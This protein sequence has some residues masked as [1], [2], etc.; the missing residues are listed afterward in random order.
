MYVPASSQCNVLNGNIGSASTAGTSAFTIKVCGI[1]SRGPRPKSVNDMHRLHKQSVVVS[2]RRQAAAFSTSRLTR[3]P[4]RLITTTLPVVCKHFQMF[5]SG[6]N[7]YYR[8]A[9]CQPRLLGLHQV[10]FPQKVDIRI[11]IKFTGPAGRIVRFAITALHSNFQ[12]LMALR[13][14]E[15]QASEVRQVF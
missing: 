4:Q 7:F 9:A 10:S 13:Q 3:G 14:L 5:Y 6:I 1:L 12:F 15:L 8:S 2:A 11:I